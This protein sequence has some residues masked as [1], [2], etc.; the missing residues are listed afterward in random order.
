MLKCPPKLYT[1]WYRPHMLGTFFAPK[2]F[3]GPTTQITYFGH[4]W[5]LNF[6]KKMFLV[7]KKPTFK[8]VYRPQ[9]IILHHFFTCSKHPLI[10]FVHISK[11]LKKYFGLKICGI[12]RNL[13]KMQN[14]FGKDFTW[15]LNKKNI[16]FW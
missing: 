5:T 9:N 11:Y 13:K 7:W 6:R 2:G 14:V 12:L 3:F 4:F 1:I 15:F 16:F 10:P 8:W